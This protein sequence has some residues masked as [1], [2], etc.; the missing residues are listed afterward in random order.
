MHDSR[1]L[2][3]RAGGDNAAKFVLVV[4]IAYAEGGVRVNRRL[5]D[6]GLE[7]VEVEVLPL[8]LPRRRQAGD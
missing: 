4:G 5:R 8:G 7:A 1:L 2:S 6:D 3:P